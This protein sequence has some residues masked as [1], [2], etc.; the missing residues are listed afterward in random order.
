MA[1][2][3]K[4]AVSRRPDS[5]GTPPETV[6]RDA[7]LAGVDSPTPS[8]MLGVAGLVLSIAAGADDPAASLDDIVRGLVT[9]GRVETLATA[10]TVATLTNDVELRRRVRREIADRGLV[11]PRWLAELDRAEP[12]GRAVEI[13]TV[14]RDV[15]TLLVGVT[16]PGGHPLTAVVHI[17]NECGAV[18]TDGYVVQGPLAA[19]VPL[20]A[21]DGDPDVRARD[22]S[23]ADARAR[24]V[25]G[26][27]FRPWPWV[28]ESWNR[29]RPVIE[30]MATRLPEG[31]RDDVQQDLSDDEMDEL[32]DRFLATYDPWLRRQLGQLVE[33]VLWAG[34]A[35]GIGDPLVWSP[36]NVRRLLDSGLS[37]LDPE[38]PLLHRAPDVLRDLICHGH[39]ERGL[40]QELTDDAL[41]AVATCAAAF[42]T[43]VRELES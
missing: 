31:G 24:I 22:V 16:V 26:L 43:A 30:W 9:A 8:P 21:G 39:A 3:E 19:V 4:P 12:V 40:R 7:L 1:K 13:S 32:V 5:R 14:F 33:G 25:T 27:R 2:T 37:A 11:L 20:L 34:R 15:D 18:A 6:F 36:S 42:R 35:N 23:P 17:D 29:S 41:A 10:L 38:T 28:S